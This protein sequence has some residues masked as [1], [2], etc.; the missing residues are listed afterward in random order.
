MPTDRWPE[1][2]KLFKNDDHLPV[3]EEIASRRLV[4]E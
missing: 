4:M 3:R 2:C 1:L